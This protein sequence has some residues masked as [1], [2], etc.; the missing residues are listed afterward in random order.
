MLDALFVEIG[1]DDKKLHSGLK[2]AEQRLKS[3]ESFLTG[4]GSGLLL[5]KG[6]DFGKELFGGFV[7]RGD[8]IKKASDRIGDTAE[9]VSLLG[10]AAE[11]SGTNLE[12]LETGIKKMQKA[13]VEG[14]EHGGEMADALRDVGLEATALSTRT[15]TDQLFAIGDALEKIDN[16][17]KRAAT[18]MKIMGKSGT[19]LIPLLKDGSKGLRS[20]M[21]EGK[22]AGAL[23]TAEEAAQSERIG[24]S[25]QRTL[26]A[27]KYT[28]QSFF[29]AIV[30][31]GDEIEGASFA[32]LR[33][34]KGVREWVEENRALTAGVLGV[35][36]AS[37]VAGGTLIALGV[38]AKVGGAGFGLL[39]TSVKLS[40]GALALLATPAGIALTTIGALAVAV[41]YLLATTEKGQGVLTFFGNGWRELADIFATTWGGINDALASGDLEAAGEIAMAGL[42][43]AWLQLTLDLRKF[44]D[45]FIN[46]FVQGWKSALQIVRTE[47]LSLQKEGVDVFRWIAKQGG[48]GGLADFM[49]GGMKQRIDKEIDKT[50]AES[51]V[52]MG[53]PAEKSEAVKKAEADAAAA[54]AKLDELNADAAV[55]RILDEVMRGK[56]VGAAL[57]QLGSG[58]L[59]RGT[60]SARGFGAQAFGG[61]S[62]VKDLVDLGKVNNQKLSAIDEHL[63]ELLDSKAVLT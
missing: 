37:V 59:A 41:G 38:A 2:A 48:A 63:K 27:A 4:L 19:E 28:L 55:G 18:A 45:D 8:Q 35:T 7:E 61:A 14:A 62:S 21:E 56:G 9:N 58:T 31:H 39:A 42:K 36:A 32:L 46:H 47:Q 40:F 34:L 10:Y 23:V 49:T 1:T 6:I 29:K 25:V 30:P 5:K 20:L 16:P 50:F 15:P 43:A 13:I 52:K 44:W 33:F 3:F 51:G 12:G 22:L 54:H 24:D 53:G 57:E 17:A 60:F 11:Q 26:T